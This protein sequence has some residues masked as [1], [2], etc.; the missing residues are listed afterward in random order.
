MVLRHTKYFWPAKIG[1]CLN[2]VFPERTYKCLVRNLPL[3]WIIIVS[4]QVFLGILVAWNCWLM[5]NDDLHIDCLLLCLVVGLRFIWNRVWSYQAEADHNHGNEGFE[6]ET[7]FKPDPKTYERTRF[8]NVV[9]SDVDHRSRRI[10]G[11][12]IYRASEKD[13]VLFCH[14]RHVGHD[15]MLFYHDQPVLVNSKHWPNGQVD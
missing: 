11:C 2:L 10:S 13:D 3:L 7:R 1:S 14:H 5:L 15:L 9:G 8:I 6:C 4:F 12:I